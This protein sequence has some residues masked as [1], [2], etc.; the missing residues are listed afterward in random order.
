MR[1]L[2]WVLIAMAFVAASAEAVLALGPGPR[3]VLATGDV[4]TLLSGVP[5]SAAAPSDHW[6][7][8]VTASVMVL[9]AW[10][11]VGLTGLLLVLV[12]RIRRR[13]HRL[14]AFD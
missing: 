9:P 1:F 10:I 11:A 12:G 14:S 3:P 5:S 4:W 7:E 6:L 2:G 13:K 8:M